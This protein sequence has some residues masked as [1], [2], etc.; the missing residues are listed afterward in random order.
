MAIENNDLFVLQKSGGGE[1]RKASV[2][3]VLAQVVTPVVPEEISDLNDVDTSGVT[4]GQILVY[5]T[6]TWVS[7]DFPEAQDL[8]NYL[9]KPGT[10]GSFVINEAADGTSTYAGAID[11]G[12]YAT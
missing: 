3:A 10:E 5:D 11:G 2:G 7:Q 6:D 9:Q 1:L 4:N 8:S 12:E